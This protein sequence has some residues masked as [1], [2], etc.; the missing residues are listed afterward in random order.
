MREGAPATVF[1]VVRVV[2]ACFEKKKWLVKDR[3]VARGVR[4]YFTVEVMVDGARVVVALVV[5]V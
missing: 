1:V 2:V 5:A 3:I 4:G